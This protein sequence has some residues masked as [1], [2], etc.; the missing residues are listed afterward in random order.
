[1][2]NELSTEDNDLNAQNWLQL[3]NR[4]GLTKCTNEFYTFYSFCGNGTQ[5]LLSKKS[6]DSDLGVQQITSDT[7]KSRR[8]VI[9]S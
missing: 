2:H 1:M 9:D 6:F 8:S 3:I 5:G 4:G 7:Q